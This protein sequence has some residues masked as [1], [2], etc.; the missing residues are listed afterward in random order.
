HG[1]WSERETGQSDYDQG[2]V[3]EEWKRRV[4][5]S[6]TFAGD[7]GRTPEALERVVGEILEP[8]VD[9]RRILRRYVLRHAKED[10]DWMRPDR[11]LLQHGIYYPSPQSERLDMAIAVDTSGSIREDVLKK[12]LSE[13]EGI[14]QSADSYRARL[15]ACDAKVH[16][17]MSIGQ[18]KG[19]DVEKAVEEFSKRLKGRGGT[20]YSPVFEA[21]DEEKIRVLV[22][23][24]DGRCSENLEKPRYDVVWVLPEGGTEKHLGF[25]EVVKLEGGNRT[26]RQTPPRASR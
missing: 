23:L 17:D 12:F 19:L 1:P 13:V 16:S 25:G 22:Y 10:Y 15:L 8:K 5:E 4:A 3:S 24:T 18:E 26:G 2:E 6:S 9:W 20:R 21:L 7:E 11:R 14:L